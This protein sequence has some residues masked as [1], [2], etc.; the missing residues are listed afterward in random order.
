MARAPLPALAVAGW[1]TLL[2]TAEAQDVPALVQSAATPPQEAVAVV[3]A[4]AS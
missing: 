2:G 3:V 1:L 4:A